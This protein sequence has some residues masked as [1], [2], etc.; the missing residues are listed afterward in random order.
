MSI[1]QQEFLALKQ[2]RKTVTEYLQE[3]NALARYAPDDVS[4]DARRQSRFM[5]GLTEEMQLALAVHEF[6]NFQHLVNKAIVVEHKSM[7]V[8]ESR[9]KRRAAIKCSSFEMWA[10]TRNSICE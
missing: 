2:G 9:K 7:A 8:E 10:S 1:K 3:F 4:T 6:R 5:N